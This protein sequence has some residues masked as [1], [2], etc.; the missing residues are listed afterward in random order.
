MCRCGRG[1]RPS[2]GTCGRG[3]ET[4]RFHQDRY[5]LGGALDADELRPCP[6]Q[7]GMWGVADFMWDSFRQCAQ[8]WKQV[9]SSAHVASVA[10]NTDDPWKQEQREFA[11]WLGIKLISETGEYLKGFAH[12]FDGYP[13]RVVQLRA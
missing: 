3:G 13:S 11:G 8:R 2:F 10:C 4:Q 9:L 7:Q 6:K 12:W 1:G 5:L